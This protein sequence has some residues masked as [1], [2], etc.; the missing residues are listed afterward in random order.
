MN[1][2]MSLN[3][4]KLVKIILSKNNFIKDLENRIVNLEFELQDSQKEF[5]NNDNNNNN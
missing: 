3:K 2:Y 4:E 5:N 1:A